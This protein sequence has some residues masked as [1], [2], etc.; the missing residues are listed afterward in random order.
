MRRAPTPQECAIPAVPTVVAPLPP[1]VIA[2]PR[3]CRQPGTVQCRRPL[4]P[5]GVH[6]LRPAGPLQRGLPLQPGPPLQP[7][8][9]LQPSGDLQP[10]LPLRP[11]PLQPSGGAVRP[12]GALRPGTGTGRGVSFRPPSGGPPNCYF[13]PAATP[14]LQPTHREGPSLPNDNPY[15]LTP[16]P[17]QGCR[18]RCM[19]SPVGGCGN[20]SVGGAK[21]CRPFQLGTAESF[22]CKALKTFFVKSSRQDLR[23][24]VFRAGGE[25]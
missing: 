5:C 24:G 16:P 12:G 23:I 19:T 25:G 14:P 15:L 22:W 18:Q 17:V 1:A 10:P 8:L 4:Q 6:L 2:G 20:Q 7:G 11:G 3:P 9:P 13:P 21:L